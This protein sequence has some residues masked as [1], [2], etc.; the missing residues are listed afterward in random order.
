MSNILDT[1]AENKRREVAAAKRVLTEEQIFS[2][3]RQLDR[4]PL[5]LKDSLKSKQD[6]GIIA[7]FK[8]KSPSKGGI[9][10]CADVETVIRGYEANGAAACSVLT[11][12]RFFGGSLADF[13]VAR[14]CAGIPLLRKDFMVDRYQIAQ[15]YIHGA[16][17]ILL[18]ASLLE[19]EE[20]KAMAATAHE[21][22]METLV[23]IHCEEE[24]AKIP[25][26]AD[27]VG[28][29]NRNLKTFV[30]DV[31]ASYKIISR[32]PADVVK[33]A[34]SGIRTHSDIQRLHAVGYDGFLIGETFMKNEN[35]PEALRNF[36]NPTLE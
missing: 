28:V 2:M 27:M 19:E 24:I 9:N 31:D 14:G 25:Q 30:T 13:D 7:E 12:T 11:D 26:G 8:R 34:E 4:K 6:G 15:A 17:A 20:M 3:A 32:L 33:V 29:N 35:P 21:F 16:D 1:I 5:S 22:G 23:E 10:P 36:L 18:I